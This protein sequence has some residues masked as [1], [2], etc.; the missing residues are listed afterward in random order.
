MNDKI[1]ETVHDLGQGMERLSVYSQW[2]DELD[3]N[4]F[5][6]EYEYIELP[7]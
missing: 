7:G 1:N 2:L 5:F 3:C 4:D 6:S